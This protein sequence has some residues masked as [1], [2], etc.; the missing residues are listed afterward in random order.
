M[1]RHRIV[2]GVMAGMFTASGA[3]ALER[4]RSPDLVPHE[5]VYAISLS[6]ARSGG[7][8]AAASGTMSYRFADVCDGWTVETHNSLDLVDEDG[9]QV[10]S[11]WDFVAWES[12]DGLDYRFRVL[13]SRDEEVTETIV[14]AAH[15]NGKGKGGEVRFEQP[16]ATTIPL[17]AGTLFPT[18]HTALMVERAMA[19]DRTILRRVFD[20]TVPAPPFEVN[21]V[22]GKALPPGAPVEYQSPLLS[23]RQSWRMH[24][25]Y[26]R[27]DTD[28]EIPFHEV[29]VRYHD[30]GVAEDVVQDYGT[31][32]LTAT[33]KE[34]KL[35]PKP[36]C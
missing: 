22:V 26:F 34:L 35:L 21:V 24:M 10:A 33:V 14:G 32:S 30:N 4:Q 23:G 6:S 11:G 20:G 7:G 12:K 27:T 8:V 13:S 29:K 28:D 36:G 5:A 25:A 19:G 2:M 15:L 16:E 9:S 17:P 18:E 3:W 1:V 31:F